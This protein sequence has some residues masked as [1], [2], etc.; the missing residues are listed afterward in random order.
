MSKWNNSPT[1]APKPMT[2]A[3][4]EAP[5]SGGGSDKERLAE[6]TIRIATALFA[7][8]KISITAVPGTAYNMARDVEKYL[9]SV[10]CLP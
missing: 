8:Q 6:W 2:V 7:A 9:V 5:P 4:S 10:G 3:A 1:E